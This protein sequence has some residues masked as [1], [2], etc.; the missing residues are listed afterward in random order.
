MIMKMNNRPIDSWI[1][2]IYQLIMFKFQMWVFWLIECESF[3][4]MGVL[5]RLLATSALLSASARCTYG[6]LVIDPSK[7]ISKHDIFRRISVTQ[8]CSDDLNYY[9]TLLKKPWKYP[10]HF[11]IN[12][13]YFQSKLF[14]S[15]ISGHDNF[16]H[17]FA[18]FLFSVG[19]NCQNCWWNNWREFQQSW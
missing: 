1:S 5:G 7:D 15:S 14:D 9:Y 12:E 16:V 10:S 18:Y 4:R 8:N 3:K 6:E 19:F 2:P 17:R 11:P 13:W